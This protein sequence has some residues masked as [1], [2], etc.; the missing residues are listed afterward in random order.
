[1]DKLTDE[2]IKELAQYNVD[3]NL[4]TLNADLD[5]R[6]EFHIYKGKLFW[7]ADKQLIF[8]EEFNM[9]PGTLGGDVE[10]EVKYDDSSES[11]DVICSIIDKALK[12]SAGHVIN[13]ITKSIKKSKSINE[14]FD[15]LNQIYEASKIKTRDEEFDDELIQKII[16]N[17]GIFY[18]IVDKTKQP[19]HYKAVQVYDENSKKFTIKRINDLDISAVNREDIENGESEFKNVVSNSK[20]KIFDKT[21][22]NTFEHIDIFKHECLSH[23]DTI[24]DVPDE[25]IEVKEDMSIESATSAESR[26]VDTFSDD[27]YNGTNPENFPNIHKLVYKD[28]TTNDYM[29]I[30][31]EISC[32]NLS[33]KNTFEWNDNNPEFVITSEKIKNTFIDYREAKKVKI[34]VNGIEI[35]PKYETEFIKAILPFIKIKLNGIKKRNKIK[36]NN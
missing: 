11:K 18:I 9:I 4:L 35:R 7:V 23:F 16:K 6:L 25:D 13:A 22:E 30:K 31:F 20:N 5:M 32:S 26:G 12:N 24:K 36:S 8:V 28:P 29:D 27:I 3:H 2:Q 14:S 33:V 34:Y 15:Y 17:K 21:G 1:M 19:G 10:F